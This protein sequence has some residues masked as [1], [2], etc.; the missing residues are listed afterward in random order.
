M[1]KFIAKLWNK[2]FKKEDVNNSIY[3][4][5]KNIPPIDY[6]KTKLFDKEKCTC[7]EYVEDLLNYNKPSEVINCTNTSPQEVIPMDRKCNFVHDSKGR[8]IKAIYYRNEVKDV[9]QEFIDIKSVEPV[10]DED[11]L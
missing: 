9:N 6:R 11:N 8:I 10:K 5:I 1:L 3:N 7:P 2:L 4:F